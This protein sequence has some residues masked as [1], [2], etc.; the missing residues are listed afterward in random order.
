[1]R[2]PG[3]PFV[4]GKEYS[5]LIGRETAFQVLKECLSH[6]EKAS[7]GTVVPVNFKNIKFLDFSAADEFIRKLIS[8]IT[9][10]EFRNIY[11]YITSVSEIL[12]ENIEAALKLNQQVILLWNSGQTPEIIGQLN[13]QLKDTWDLVN[14][15]KQLTARELAD[16][17]GLPINTSSNR[18]AKLY[19]LGL[20][21][22][23]G[24]K[25]ASGGGQEYIY[26]S[27]FE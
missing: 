19:T 6:L 8:R 7:L 9:G 14:H 13:V 12:K 5:L 3:I 20:I 4:I 1:M 16:T 10:K 27:I 15:K 24:K 2:N 22:Q 18:L 25:G 23:S 17:M 11:I 21:H 26:E